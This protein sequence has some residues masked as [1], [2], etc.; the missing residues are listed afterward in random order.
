[1][2]V[3]DKVIIVTGASEGIGKALAEALAPKGAKLVLVARSDDKIAD[4]VAK[5]PGAL[6]VH[7]DMRQEKDID[8]MVEA[9][10]RKH[11]RI[12]ILINNAGQG[13]YGPLE[14][15]DIGLYKSVM[16]LNIFAPLRAMQ[17]VIPH[18]RK[19]GGGMIVNIS[20]NV[21]KNAFPNLSA[22]ASTKYALNA[23]SY[24]AR[25]ELAKDNIVVSVMH[26]RLTS[27]R[28]GQNAIGSRPTFANRA[29]SAAPPV[30]TPEQVAQKVLE[31]IGTG[32]QE[33]TM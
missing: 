27:T 16:E 13:M 17:R 2:D 29:G 1:M 12:D 32:A 21:S 18:M 28:F 25:A 24:T 8:A 3:K 10:I 23:L 11:G 14:T 22:Y 19:A 30:D 26:P 15:I 4:L 7:A 31:L 5:I 20:S 6:G 33:A 9:T